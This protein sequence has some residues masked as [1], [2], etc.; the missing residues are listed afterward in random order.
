MTL[1]F[2]DQTGSLVLLA[3]I[4]NT[5]APSDLRSALRAMRMRRRCGVVNSAL[6][7]QVLLVL[8]EARVHHVQK[9]HTKLFWDLMHA[10]CVLMAFGRPKRALLT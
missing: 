3:L 2:P 7:M 1:D 5:I 9:A 10:H 8:M 4:C 6:A